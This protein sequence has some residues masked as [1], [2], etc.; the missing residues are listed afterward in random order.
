MPRDL[1]RMSRAEA[2]VPGE[3]VSKRTGRPIFSDRRRRRRSA[4]ERASCRPSSTR[5]A[6]RPVRV[7]NEVSGSVPILGSRMAHL[8]RRISPS[9]R[10]NH[11]ARFEAMNSMH[12][13][14]T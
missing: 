8:R 13:P 9:R 14:L 7:P 6:H 11:S 4:S 12:G 1:R 3:S 2:A 5:G 10:S